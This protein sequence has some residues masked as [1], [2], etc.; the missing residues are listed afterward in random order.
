MPYSATTTH[1]GRGHALSRLPS[2]HW[3]CRDCKRTRRVDWNAKNPE[4]VVRNSRRGNL[5]RLYGLTP[6][7]VEVML[8]AQNGCCAACG[9][10]GSNPRSFAGGLLIDHCHRTGQVRGL[11]C[12]VCNPALALLENPARYAALKNYLIRYTTGEPV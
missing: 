9:V 11:L 6:E 3:D 2:G 5:K 7:Q 4:S 12:N 8:T 1:C 10:K